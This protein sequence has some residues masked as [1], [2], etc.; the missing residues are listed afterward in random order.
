MIRKQVNMR[1]YD[2]T[3]RSG[4]RQ[5]SW[6]EFANLSA[7][8]AELLEPFNPEVIV[9][10]ARAGLLPAT[11]VASSLR[12]E[13]FPVRLTRRKDDIVV[14]DGPIWKVPLSTEVA[15]KVVAVIDEIADSGETLR[16]VVAEAVMLGASQVISAC[17]V[18]HT[19][20]DPKPQV[21]A[22]VSD[23]L[24]IF[25][26]DRRVLADGQWVSHP[27]ILSAL[28]AQSGPSG[29]PAT[30][31]SL[32]TL[33]VRRHTM[34][35]IPDQHLTQAGVELARRIGESTGP[36]ERIVTS[37]VPRAFETALAMGFAVDEQN[38][39]LSQ[40]GPGVE[41]EV[42]WDAGFAAF[43][44]AVQLGAATARFARTQADFWHTAVENLSDGGSA[45]LVTH[46]GFVEAG[47]VASLPQADHEAWGPF[48]DYCEGVRLYFDGERFTNIQILRIH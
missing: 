7:H 2:Y 29:S 18:S 1:S 19:W 16:M 4:V 13:L 5:I 37:T 32:R 38:E 34:R 20:A 43:A 3:R 42:D 27:E 11:T 39:I 36:F 33:E 25:P 41:D 12:R 9:G 21:S 10:I 46:G 8:L 47:A 28:A 26:W 40:L 44:R 48:C 15:G 22:L 31:K 23:E 30:A 6:G 45:L 35:L 24:I 14:Y 17:L